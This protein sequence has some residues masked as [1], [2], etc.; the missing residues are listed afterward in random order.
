MDFRHIIFISLL[1]L[2][3]VGCRKSVVDV[4]PNLPTP[5]TLSATVAGS[6][7]TKAT[8]DGWNDTP[9]NILGLKRVPGGYDFDDQTNILDREAVISAD[10]Q[11]YLYSDNHAGTPYYYQEGQFYD[12]Y[13]Y[14]LGGAEV[15]EVLKGKDDYSLSVT[16]FGN[17]DLLYANTDKEKDLASYDG[18]ALD[19]SVLYSAISARRN[20]HPVLRFSH[21]LTRFKFIVKGSGDKFSLFAVSG[22][23]VEAGNTGILVLGDDYV[24][25]MPSDQVSTLSLKMGDEEFQESEITANIDAVPLGGDNASLMVNPG[26]KSMKVTM[27]LLQRSENRHEEYSFVVNS[28]EI[29]LTDENG[30]T[31]YSETF[32]PGYSYRI[33]MHVYGPEEII[34]NASVESWEIGADFEIN[35]DDYDSPVVNP[36]TP[37]GEA[38]GDG[39][40]SVGDYDRTEDLGNGNLE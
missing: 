8:I 4:D 32:L 39:G 3:M 25:Y 34:I 1:L 9:V 20:V 40:I 5:V 28:S 36:Q 18:N 13:G 6:T 11:I 22:L 26:A 17:N 35:P 30:R 23:E 16:V 14:H 7:G 10:S 38:V 27:G 29:P 21:A 24:G 15:T 19:K 33:I 12:F 2:A 31:Y 37:A